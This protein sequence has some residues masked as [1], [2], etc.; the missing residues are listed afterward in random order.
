MAS[1]P[2]KDKAS[3]ESRSTEVIESRT[4]AAH[5][6]QPGQQLKG[7]YLIDRELGRGGI[8]VVYL[9]RDERLHSMPVVIKFLL[10]DSGKSSWLTRKFRQEAE[11][12]TRIN[13]PGVVRV[14]DRDTTDDGRPFF[15]MEFV[16]G[17]PLRAAMTS[18]GVNL[19]YAAQLIRQ[20]GTALHAAHQQG[21]IHRDL[22]PENI[23]LQ[24][25]TGGEEQAKLID[26]GIA[27]VHDS[28]SGLAT[29][30]AVIAGSLQY[31]A[32]E[33]LNAQPVSPATDLYALGIIVYELLTGRRPFNPDAP[34]YL[35]AA[36]QLA[37]MQ[38][39]ESIV[40]PRAL[41]PSLSEDAEALILSALRFDP[42]LRPQDARVF[43]DDLARAL[44]SGETGQSAF[45]SQSTDVLSAARPVATPHQ[46][47]ATVTEGR[48]KPRIGLVGGA[49]AIVVLGI[50]GIFWLI[51]SKP[52]ATQQV[53]TTAPVTAA[54]RTF[55]Y[56]I[57]VQ[58]DP[59]RYPGSKP[60]QLPGEVIFSPGDRIRLTVNTPQPGFLYIINESPDSSQNLLFPSSTSN[61]GSAELAAGQSIQ[62]PERGDGFV[63]DDQQ[64]TEKLW[65]IWSASS[66]PQLEAVKRWAN[67][68]D[69]GQIK[70][71]TEQ[72]AIRE[73]L[74]RTPEA[75]AEKDEA[76]R[77]TNV[78]GSTDILIK[79][80]KLEHH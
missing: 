16:I 5:I 21:V 80:V 33:Q 38:Q 41:R 28:Q 72:N 66:V 3:P 42:R 48:A 19:E 79:L 4:K 32:P 46:S 70:D 7:R 39:T 44:Q 77:Q 12:L 43:V 36:Q 73:L 13:H 34:G 20:I 56:S 75:T 15:V 69:R 9:A 14:I 31:M 35:A 62:I 68:E 52:D 40:P 6:L 1:D 71:I 59:V 53:T 30:V 63:F 49:I 8:G 37:G 54:A 58:K 11:A 2:L 10:D 57:T 64:G 47:S 23:L 74:G 51:T 27:K 78:R 22:K 61:V 76:R 26:F 55:S 29:E 17:Q 25:L 67:P 65:L 60:F 45:S 24:S 50:A 18:T